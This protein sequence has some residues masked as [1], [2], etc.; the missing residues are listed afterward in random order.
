MPPSSPPPSRTYA[1]QP[2]AHVTTLRAPKTLARATRD[3]ALLLRGTRL[4][5]LLLLLLC[6]AL[7]LQSLAL[8]VSFWRPR[9]SCTCPPPVG[10]RL[11]EQLLLSDALFV[12]RVVR[13]EPH[14]FRVHTLLSGA[15]PLLRYAFVV[16][17]QRLSLC[18]RHPSGRNGASFLLVAHH[19]RRHER[20]DTALVVPF[21]PD[22]LDVQAERVFLYPWHELSRE[23]ADYLLSDLDASP[24]WWR[25]H[26]ALRIS[27]DLVRTVVNSSYKPHYPQWWIEQGVSVV[28]ACKDRSQSLLQALPTW[29]AA[30]GVHQVVLVDWSSSP[31]IA[32]VLPSHVRRNPKLLLVTV[33]QQPQWILSTAYNLAVRIASRS[34]IMKLDCDT[35]L[36]PDFFDAHHLQHDTFFAGDWHKLETAASEKLHANGLLY[37]SRQHFL[38][39][40]GYDERITTYGWDDSDIVSRLSTI[41]TPYSILYD[42]IAHISHNASLRVANTDTILPADN[43]HAAAVEIQRN[44]LMITHFHLPPW[45]ASSLHTLWNLHRQYRDT[46]PDLIYARAANAVTPALHLISDADAL[47]VS[48][49][50]IRLILKR[51][52]VELLPKS[53]SLQFYKQLI[54]KLAH[55]SQYAN[56]VFSL[57][58]GCVSR[59]LAHVQIKQ[60]TSPGSAQYVSPPDPYIGWRIQEVW[61]FPT[62]ECSCKFFSPFLA[63][64]EE[65]TSTWYDTEN[66]VRISNFLSASRHANNVSFDL[67][68]FDKF[69][70]QRK[71]S[72]QVSRWFASHNESDTSRIM[73]ASSACHFDPL[74]LTEHEKQ[75]VRAQLR[76]TT[77][78]QT[79]LD[80]LEHLQSKPIQCLLDSPFLQ[81]TE[82]EKYV[83]PGHRE[84]AFDMFSE[85]AFIEMTRKWSPAFL[86]QQ[87]PVTASRAESL[88]VAMYSNEM[89]P[90]PPNDLEDNSM[91]P[92][93]HRKLVSKLSTRVAPLFTGCVSTPFTYIDAY[94]ELAII[95]ASFVCSGICV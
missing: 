92:L 28:A 27:T 15:A 32:S 93:E 89:W 61:H 6:T 70:I 73:F 51:Y 19:V 1:I 33:Q 22:C 7:L 8:I 35:V 65:I 2:H 84:P 80:M 3:V 23:V 41:A 90:A 26:N 72:P 45:R 75:S 53:L 46:E 68:L 57:R 18:A 48:K 11:F 67:R 95:I 58:G 30:R 37:V 87:H 24:N 82:V 43:P 52:G 66:P 42:K 69:A 86:P 4:A 78:T 36:Q 31:T 44:R 85:P 88:Y 10:A 54:E 79:L 56:V 20:N 25:H 64:D 5:P 29:L 62:P 21:A 77:P 63:V 12:A 49:R 55:V 16:V 83:Q 81:R 40:G 14:L 76:T 9:A 74:R 94:P 17:T 71:I 47:D 34:T 50:A 39:V 59:L 91:I 38:A 13:I 60:A